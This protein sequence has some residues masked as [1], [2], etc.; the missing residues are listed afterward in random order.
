[1]GHVLFVDGTF[2]VKHIHLKKVINKPSNCDVT[3]RYSWDSTLLNTECFIDAITKSLQLFPV[4]TC[5]LD[6]LFTS[7]LYGM[8][9]IQTK[10]YFPFNG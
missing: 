9:F 4:D 1:M 7:A 6:F 8:L 5:M 2:Y 3:E 10:V